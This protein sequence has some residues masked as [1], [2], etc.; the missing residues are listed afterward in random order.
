M[1]RPPV[2][3]SAAASR[4]PVASHPPGVPGDVE[5]SDAVPAPSRR[6][7]VTLLIRWAITVGLIVVLVRSIDVTA[8]IGVART[9]APWF[10]FAAFS[11]ALVDRVVMVAKWY[12]LLRVQAPSIGFGRALRVTLAS[13]VTSLLLPATVGGDVV[14]AVV[15]GRTTGRTAEIGASILVERLLGLLSGMLYTSVGVLI[16][17][18]Y[19]VAASSLIP[20]ML[21]VAVAAVIA[22]ALPFT[23]L[24]ERLRHAVESRL[25]ARWLGLARRFTT[26]YAAYRAHGTMLVKVGAL[27]VMEQFLPVIVYWLLARAVGLD[28]GF[29]A[30]LGV[31]PITLFISRMPISIAGIGVS[32]GTVVYLLRLFGVPLTEALAIALL[33]RGVGLT[34]LLPGAFFASDLSPRRDPTDRGPLAT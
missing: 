27:T 3:N 1:S 6:R 10:L 19:G 5:T 20:L 26:A 22:L 12:P 16:A 23:P 18:R 32:E 33:A 17:V 7:P 24:G 30:L 15:L 29:V 25:R 34:A 13:N 31:V 9:A 21:G 8:A 11:V 2:V 14:R 28:L 4:I